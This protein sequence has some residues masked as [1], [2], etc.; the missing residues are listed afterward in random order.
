MPKHYLLALIQ[1]AVI[2]TLMLGCGGSSSDEEQF[3]LELAAVANYQLQ[4][5]DTLL[6]SVNERLEGLAI[7]TF[8]EE[9]F[10]ILQ[11]RNSEGAI[12][13]GLANQSPL[14]TYELN[15]I[16]D[17]FA[18]QTSAIESLILQKLLSYD[19]E[20][21]SFDDKLSFDIYQAYLENQIEW[22]N[23]KNFSFPA[24]FGFFGYPG[25][26]EQFFTEIVPI[27]SKQDADLYLYLLNQIGR[28]FNQ[29]ETL[30]ETRQAA[31]II[32][33]AITLTFS[34][35]AVRAMANSNVSSTSYYTNFEEKISQLSL[36]SSDRSELMA[37]LRL[38]IEQRV[39]PAYQS[40]SDKMTEL[41]SNAP[42]NIGFG[43]YEGGDEFYQFVLNYY[44]S[45]EQTPA[46]IHQLGLDELARIHAEMRVIFD[47]LGYP[48]NESLGQ[49][50]TRVD[51]DGG[52]INGSNA[53]AFYED[54]I[55]EAYTRLPE[56]FS[57]IPEQQV[58]VIGGD[59]GGFYIR[60]SD[61]GSRPGAFYANTSSNLAYTRMPTL[62][63]HEA[64]PGH[65][66]QIALAQE[67]SLPEF[68]RRI[69]FT[70]FVEGWGLYA[71]RLAKDLG[72]YQGDPYGDL[73]RLQFEAMRAA[74]LVI[75]TGI[76]DLG[77]SYTQA[78]QFHLENV[79]YNGSIAR[80][81]VFPGQ[82]TAYMTG[83][84]SILEFRDRAEQALG[85]N[86]DIKAFHS[87]VIGSGSMPTNLLEELIDRYIE[88]NLPSSSN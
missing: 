21:L 59:T 4:P 35:D 78:D 6:A 20:V 12:S 65:H 53:V 26:T 2:L 73:G 22:F 62:A 11:E 18:E 54:I 82:A 7:Q 19:V 55:A 64:V 34:R 63:Y 27:N 84:L 31:G 79:G 46:E 24:S 81:S 76:H 10:A 3:D 16:S 5:T 43:Q 71:E 9:S 72:W 85:D 13:E 66:L 88:E 8:F 61:D 77:W 52:T 68:R 25:A 36:P 39:L 40:L 41:L 29:I 75:D 49:L 56:V 67:L 87:T 60:G 23:Y 58:I 51:R 44:T 33:P 14:G 17:E 69:N 70:S 28:R 83:M 30:L 48:T 45:G 32:E 42:S 74:R 37:L 57:T 1:S 86:Y 15:N 38:T 50:F 47:Q 80:Y